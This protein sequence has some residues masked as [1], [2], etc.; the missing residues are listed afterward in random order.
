MNLNINFQYYEN[1]YV[2]L[3]FNVF[4]TSN[5]NEPFYF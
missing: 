3:K 5:F 4:E 2:L 1:S